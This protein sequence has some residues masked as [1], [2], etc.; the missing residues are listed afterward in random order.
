SIIIEGYGLSEASPVTHANPLD[1]NL[2]KVGSIG[3]PFPSTDSKIVD[4]DDPTKDLPAGEIG[5]L[6]VKGPQVMKGYHNKP[7]ETKM[8]LTS[9]G[10]LITGDIAKMDEDGWTYIV[11]RKKDLINASGYKVWPNDV[12]EV[13]FEHPKIREVAVIGIPDE[14]RGETVK[15]F[16]VVE[17]G[18]TLTLKEMRTFGKEKM[19]VYK[20]PTDLEVVESLPKTMVGKVLRREL[21]GKTE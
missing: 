3:L 16:V 4:L 6:A 5:E 13:L 15:A 18:Q 1:K 14:K 12:E 8:V 17:P 10:W 19:A 21:R 11:D 2:R 7:D 9:D 20:V